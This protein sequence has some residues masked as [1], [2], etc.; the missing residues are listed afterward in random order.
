VAA[1]AT[2]EAEAEIVVAAV[3]AAEVEAATNS[4]A[5]YIESMGAFHHG[6]PFCCGSS[7]RLKAARLRIGR[8]PKPMLAVPSRGTVSSH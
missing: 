3:V 1:D 5:F 8:Q 7:T 2:A 6:T 4:L